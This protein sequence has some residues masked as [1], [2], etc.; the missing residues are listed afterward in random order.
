MLKSFLKKIYLIS[1][2]MSKTCISIMSCLCFSSF[3]VARQIR[4]MK[5]GRKKDK[6]YI[7]GNGPA[8]N[9][10]LK[11]YKNDSQISVFVVNMM[12]NN[13]VFFKIKPNNYI[14]ADTNYW[15]EGHSVLKPGSKRY[16]EF[17]DSKK[18]FFKNLEKV[19]WNMN[20]YIPNDCPEK[21]FKSI[22]PSIRL[23]KYN[24]TPIEGWKWVRHC[25]YS[26]GMGMPR[27]VNVVNAAV[28][29]A[30]MSGFKEID[31]FGVNHSWM[32]D[33]RVDEQGRIYTKDLHFYENPE[34]ERYYFNKGNLELSLRSMADAFHSH[35]MLEVY[36]KEKGIQIYNCTKHSFIDAYEFKSSSQS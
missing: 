29:C 14:I 2:Q 22:N 20:L 24:R 27:P 23:I 4:K 1:Q 26:L 15:S 5:D 8:L 33:F 12:A 30:I 34:K 17:M 28:Y 16:E 13:E 18:R 36:A 21:L 11:S 9:D 3:K 25:L 7:L 19:D 35:Y 6:C 32:L 10:L 31:L